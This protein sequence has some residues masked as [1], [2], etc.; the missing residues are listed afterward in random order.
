ME[1]RKEWMQSIFTLAGRDNPANKDFQLW[2]SDNHPIE[3]YTFD[4][5]KQ[6]LDY[7]H[8]NPVRAGLVNAPEHWSYSSAL[9]YLGGESLI[10][11]DM[12]Y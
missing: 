2:K 1:S 6:K 10:E 3:L 12:L 7:I 8:N 4:V 11:I 5:A 9:T